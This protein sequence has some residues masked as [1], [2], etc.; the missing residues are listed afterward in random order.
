MERFVKGDI[1]VVPFPNTDLSPAK[2][3]PAFV[4]T[5]LEGDDVIIC[6]ITSKAHRDGY[7]CSLRIEDMQ[8]G[9]LRQESAI[10]PNRL[11]TMYEGAILYKI[12][13]VK[14]HKIDEVECRLKRILFKNNNQ[15]KNTGA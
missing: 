14:D 11:F 5:S 4:I 2:R 9:A 1:V 15:N 10:R 8:R 13:K 3:R 6:Q 12:G 7:A